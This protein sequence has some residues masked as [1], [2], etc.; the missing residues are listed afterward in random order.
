[1]R[2][3]DSWLTGLGLEYIIP[4]LKANGITTP[5]KLAQ[6]TLRD[7]YEVVGVEDTEDRKKLYFL[8]QRLHTILNSKAMEEPE[9][10]AASGSPASASPPKKNLRIP[11]PAAVPAYSKCPPFLPAYLPSLST[12]PICRI[13]CLLADSACLLPT[14]YCLL[15]TAYCLLPVTRILL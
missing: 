10:E 7:M 11:A 6:L 9:T 14:A 4:K 12:L 2:Y 15:P 13:A 5:K 1:M 8:I 3:I